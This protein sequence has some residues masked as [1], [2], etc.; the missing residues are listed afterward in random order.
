MSDWPTRHIQAVKDKKLS[1]EIKVQA[2]KASE[3]L[4]SLLMSQEVQ[5]IIIKNL[6][7]A[8]SLVH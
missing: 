3:K 5:D 7:E 8:S 4:L 2:V 1:K 6:L